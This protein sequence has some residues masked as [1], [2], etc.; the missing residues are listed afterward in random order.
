MAACDRCEN[1]IR[2]SVKV[3]KYCSQLCTCVRG[4]GRAL[5][6]GTPLKRVCDRDNICARAFHSYFFF[7][8]FTKGHY[9]E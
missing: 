4:C 3:C 5:C 6:S 9:I 2:L 7:L 8:H 1:S